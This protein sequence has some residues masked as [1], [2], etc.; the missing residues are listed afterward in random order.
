VTGTFHLGGQSAV[1]VQ[2]AL[3]Q[4]TQGTGAKTSDIDL[5]SLKSSG[6]VISYSLSGTLSASGF[7]CDVLAGSQQTIQAPSADAP[8]SVNAPAGDYAI[9]VSIVLGFSPTTSLATLDS[10]KSGSLVIAKV[11]AGGSTDVGT[12]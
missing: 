12:F 10:D 5:M 4:V 7:S 9:V 11:T 2:V 1:V 8:F 6:D 3:C